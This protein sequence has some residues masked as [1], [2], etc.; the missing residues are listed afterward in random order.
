MEITGL[1]ACKLDRTHHRTHVTIAMTHLLIDLRLLMCDMAQ[2]FEPFRRVVASRHLNAFDGG[3]KTRL[4]RH[5]TFKRRI[6]ALAARMVQE[7]MDPEPTER[8]AV[9]LL[10]HLFRRLRSLRSLL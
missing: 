2:I 6:N 4:T 3:D 8:D 5:V 9:P 7:R 10:G 1:A